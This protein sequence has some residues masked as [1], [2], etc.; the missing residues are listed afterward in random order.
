[1]VSSL[2]IHWVGSCG[3]CCYNTLRYVGGWDGT[4]AAA[5]A[6]SPAAAAA[7]A[8]SA[9]DADGLINAQLPLVL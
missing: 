4:A 7:A 2:G 9:A 6:A 8:T 1:M 5:A 3:V